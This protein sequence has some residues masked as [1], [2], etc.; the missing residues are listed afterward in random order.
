MQVIGFVG[1]LATRKNPFFAISTF[2]AFHA[3][4]SDNLLVMLGKGPLESEIVARINDA[5]LQHHFIQLDYLKNVNEMVLSN[6]RTFFPTPFEE[7]R[8]VPVEAQVSNLKVLCADVV[9]HIPYCL[10]N[11]KY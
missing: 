6:G 3:K 4:H 2:E 7:F 8:L 11:V 10:C 9:P 5:R 1:V